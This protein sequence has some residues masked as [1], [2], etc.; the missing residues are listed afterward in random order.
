[1]NTDNVVPLPMRRMA[2]M[3]AAAIADWRTK[4]PTGIRTPAVYGSAVAA[5]F[6]FGF[7]IWAVTAPIDGAVIAAGVVQAS[8]R[9]EVVQH[10]EGGIVGSISVVEGQAVKAGEVLLSIDTLRIAAERN[11][12]KVAL[13]AS[14]AQLARAQAERDGMPELAIDPGLAAGALM[15]GAVED[16]EQQQ[17]EFANRTQRHQAELAAVEQRVKATQEEIEGLL[18][19]KTSE[20]RKLAVLRE[21]LEGKATLRAKGLVA[22]S[23]VNELQRAEAD[24]LGA[25]GTLTA[26]IGQ[27]RALIA[28]L[29]QQSA[30]IEAKRREAASTEINDLS[31]K[32]GDLREQLRSHDDKL[33]RSQ[34]R[35]ASAGVVVK[36]TKNSVGSVIKPGEVVAEMV[37]SNGELLIDA[38]VRPHDIA[39]VK[40]GQEATLRVTALNARTTPQL[41]AMVRYVSADRFI[42]PDTREPYYTARLEISGTSSPDATRNKIQPGMPVDAFIKTGERSFLGYLVRPVQDS[43]AKAF[44]EE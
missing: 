29:A 19:Q 7:G 42:D 30:G 33:A 38:R 40:V 3:R 36:M 20:E 37:P 44:R 4:V 17:A 12:V 28:E 5:V 16:I 15:A 41:P 10:L 14:E 27:R 6:I 8:G 24:A 32:I 35:A 9:N 22:K 34:I 13:I 21:E 43:F 23:Q 2:P 31:S 25:I 18:I 39:A 26:T 11:R 1:M